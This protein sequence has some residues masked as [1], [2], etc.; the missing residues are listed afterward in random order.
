MH[1]TER[2]TRRRSIRKHKNVLTEEWN[3]RDIIVVMLTT[4]RKSVYDVRWILNAT[5][6][7]VCTAF[8]AER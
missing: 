6:Y 3:S 4:N 1:S 7:V 5:M 8:Y 2:I